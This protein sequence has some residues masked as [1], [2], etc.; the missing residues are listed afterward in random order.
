MMEF[1]VFKKINIKT[2]FQFS[3]VAFFFLY[4][5]QYPVYRWLY[6]E[7]LL[8]DY[9]TET[10]LLAYGFIIASCILF[11][12]SLQLGLAGKNIVILPQS[13]IY[14]LNFKR[15]PLWLVI[16]IFGFFAAWSYLMVE[17]KIGMTIYAD[18]DPLPFKMIGILFYGR[19]ILQPLIL[20]IIAYSFNTSNQRWLII[21]LLLTIGAYVSYASG[22]RFVGILFSFPLLVATTGKLRWLIWLLGGSLFTIIAT[23]SR[24]FYL[25]F[26][27]GG[28]LLQ[29]YANEEI[30]NSALENIWLLPISYLF[31]R[32]MGINEV[33]MTLSFGE[34][35]R[36]FQDALLQLL[37]NFIF[38]IPPGVSVS[39]K[40]IYGLSDDAFGGFGLDFF[41]N[42]WVIYGGT[43][44]TYMIGL[45][46]TGW[47]LGRTYRIVMR[48][49][50]KYGMNER[51]HVFIFIVLF[52]LVYEGRS[53]L[54]LY[55]LI[56]GWLAQQ[57]I[58]I[59]IYKSFLRGM[60]RT[61]LRRSLI[62][63]SIPQIGGN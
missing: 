60:P 31:G 2:P 44:P 35:T 53:R 19:L 13:Q 49:M 3:I 6:P 23:L 41:S 34:I 51:F 22:S 9:S 55:L 7:I 43:I 56:F 39:I 17:L 21:L 30:Q 46:L 4:V 62:H 11:L 28:D 52:L 54:L 26:V 47:L 8:I 42:Y 29:I 18:F 48:M 24:N 40:N 20:V 1:P 25:P 16:T 36:T 14:N 33:L 32:S 38:F 58:F 45:M 5:I 10:W 27:I 12:F 37:S 61:S 15:L 57:P 59:R 50:F 63:K